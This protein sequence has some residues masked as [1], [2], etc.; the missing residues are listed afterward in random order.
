M[1][2]GYARISTNKQNIQ[3]QINNIRALYPD[4]DIRQEA[5]TGTIIQRKEFSKLVNNDVKTGDTIVFDSVSRM[6]RNA[7]EGVKQY[8]ELYDKGVDL[9]FLKER[10]IDTDTYKSAL[11]RSIPLTGDDVDEVLIGI[12]KYLRKLA[13]RQIELAFAQAQKEVDDLHQR[14][15]EGI[16][17]ARLN[18]KQI[19]QRTGATLNI[20]KKSPAKSIIAKHSKSFGGSLS[21][22]EVMTLA[23]LSRNTYYRYKSE[24]AE[25]LQAQADADAAKY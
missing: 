9:V 21:D 10:H 17:T 4:A 18:G 20:K 8:F 19:G 16:R 25:E 3:R 13:I 5:Y 2:Y 14:T 12:N 23:G 24:V 11:S 1:I 15:A 6:S 7:E 22:S